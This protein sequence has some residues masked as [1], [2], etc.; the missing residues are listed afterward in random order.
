MKEEQKIAPKWLVW[1]GRFW[2]ADRE[3]GKVDYSEFETIPATED[4]LRQYLK[5]FGHKAAG[6][7]ILPKYLF[8][9]PL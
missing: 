7:D 6:F 3:T 1:T 4:D 8:N 9:M 5:T 2:G